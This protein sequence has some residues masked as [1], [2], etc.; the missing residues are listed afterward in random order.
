VIKSTSNKEILRRSKMYEKIF[1]PLDGSELAEVALPYVEEGAGKLWTEIILIS[2]LVP[3]GGTDKDR[4]NHLHRFYLEKMADAV[5]QGIEKKQG[6]SVAKKIKIK[7]V[8]LV[9]DPA[10]KIV[11]YA[12]KNKTGLIIMSTH[13]LTGIKRWAVGSVA[14]KVVKAASPPVVLIR[15]KGAPSD[16]RKRDIFEKMLVPLD[17]SKDSEAVIPYV[18]ELAA[19]VKKEVVLFHV[20]ASGGQTLI[21]SEKGFTTYAD[22]GLAS[23]DITIKDYFEYPPKS[24]QTIYTDQQ[25]ESMKAAA[26][27]YLDKV[28]GGFKRKGVTVKSEV[29]LGDAARE[30]IRYADEIKADLV[31]MS[32]RGRFVLNESPREFTSNL[33]SIAEKIVHSGNTPLMLV[34]PTTNKK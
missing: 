23:I 17:G 9:G 21:S 27:D 34:K 3:H 10:E 7:S 6:D 16:M 28:G 5:K 25:T 11:D 30:I 33:G 22:Q 20:L 18:E 4:Y 1:V 15:A 32:A 26:R 8:V 2:V 12:D 19:K 14:Y 24:K 31:A 13:G 29:R